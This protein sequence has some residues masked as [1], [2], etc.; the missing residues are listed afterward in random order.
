MEYQHQFHVEDVTC[1]HCEARV[2]NALLALPGAQVVEL[3][4][5]PQD[6]AEVLFTTTAVLAPE[7]I[8]AAITQQS[9]GTTHHYR[10]RWDAPAG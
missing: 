2:R 4:R 5:T 6:E 1:E 10:V 8:E 9:I 7:Q 3:V